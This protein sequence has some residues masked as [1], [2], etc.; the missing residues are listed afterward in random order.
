MSDLAAVR[1]HSKT[2]SIFSSR[3]IISRKR[4]TAGD[5]S[6]V[7][8]VARPSR[9]VSSSGADAGDSRPDEL[10]PRRVAAGWTARRRSP[11]ARARSS[12]RRGAC[13]RR[14][15]STCR[16]RSFPGAGRQKAQQSGAQRRLHERLEPR[17]E[18]RGSV[19]PGHSAVLATSGP[20][21]GRQISISA[22]VP[23]CDRPGHSG[24]SSVR[25]MRGLP[26]VADPVS[27][28]RR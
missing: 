2:T 1:I 10:E 25:G 16:G 27:A 4:C 12:A 23:F 7:E 28:A 21:L 11:P 13:G 24:R 26:R 15:P 20:E 19:S 5:W 3:P 14:P 17:F 18:V 6:S 8:T 9:N 22:S